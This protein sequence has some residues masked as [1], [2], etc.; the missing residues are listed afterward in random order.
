MKYMNANI[1]DKKE[2]YLKFPNDLVVNG[3]KGMYGY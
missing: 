1:T 2:K 3:L